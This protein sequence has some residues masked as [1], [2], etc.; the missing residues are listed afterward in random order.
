MLKLNQFDIEDT[1]YGRL[2]EARLKVLR[3]IIATG[4]IGQAVR[5]AENQV[6]AICFDRHRYYP[7]QV[8]PS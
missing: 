4:K 2:Y 7:V 3:D 5:W 1:D 6:V 8:P